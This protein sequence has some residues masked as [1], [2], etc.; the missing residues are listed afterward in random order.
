MVSCA[1]AKTSNMCVICVVDLT[2]MTLSVSFENDD[3]ACRL[4]WFPFWGLPLLSNPFPTSPAMHSNLC[5][6]HAQGDS[7]KFPSAFLN[8]P[9]FSYFLSCVTRESHEGAQKCW[10]R[11]G[12]GYWICEWLKICIQISL[13]IVLAFAQI[14]CHKITPEVIFHQYRFFCVLEIECWACPRKE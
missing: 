12:A 9:K 6:R 11:Q 5:F 8:S 7:F 2:M 13:G 3:N 4:G 14:L 1:A 10:L